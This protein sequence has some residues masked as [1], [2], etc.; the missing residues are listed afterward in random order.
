MRWQQLMSGERPTAGEFS[1]PAPKDHRNA[2][3][4]DWDRIVFSTA[5]RRLHDKTQV[6]PLPEDDV[7][8]SRLTHSLEV[9]SVG[10]SLGARVGEVLCERHR[11][12]GL[13]A[14]DFGDVA[15][16]A[17]LA[18]DIGNPPFG[19][20]GEDAI[21][22]YF[23]ERGVAALENLTLNEREDLTQFEGNAQGFRI[24]TRLQF[25]DQGGLRLTAAT[26]GAFLKYPRESA[27]QLKD[28]A[29]VASKKFG[30]F[31]SEFELL[32]R[33]A[34][35]LELPAYGGGRGWMRHPMAYVVEA[36]DDICNSMLDLEDGVQ[37]GLVDSRILSDTLIAIARRSKG[38]D[39]RRHERL[40]TPRE[41]IAYL[42]ALTIGELVKD[43]AAVFL[44]QDADLLAG[45]P[46]G[47]LKNSCADAEVLRSLLKIAR[48]QCYEA[49]DVLEIELAGYQV[50]G[51]M[52]ECFVPAVLRSATERTPRERRAQTLL[53][54]N[55]ALDGV[56]DYE[57]ILRVTDHVSGMTD[58]YALSTYHKLSGISLPSRGPMPGR[59]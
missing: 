58:R 1:S 56:T 33:L 2:F 14:S 6:F 48:E 54:R 10:R 19:H 41:E 25:G 9:A 59:A 49:V 26:L 15:A 21:G 40:N 13:G 37:L 24:L 3:Q 53:S 17:C 52:L 34:A 35:L 51:G 23:R 5:F 22:A 50:L 18:H 32:E 36:A 12:Q 11:L 57:K 47:P 29:G 44:D 8:H 7:V 43:C 31:Q 45:K 39:K 27:P 20:A 28:T 38:Y 16:A 55:G 4:K 30:V 42:R 46:V